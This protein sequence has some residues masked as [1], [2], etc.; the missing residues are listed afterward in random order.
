MQDYLTPTTENAEKEEHGTSTE[1]SRYVHVRRQV[2]RT[3]TDA[4]GKDRNERSRTCRKKRG[5]ENDY[6]ELGIGY[7]Q[8]SCQRYLLATCRRSRCKTTHTL[9]GKIAE[10]G[11]LSENSEKF[12]NF[13][14]LVFPESNGFSERFLRKIPHLGYL[15]ID[16]IPQVGYNTRITLGSG[17]IS[18][19]S[20]VVVTQSN[21][22]QQA[23][24]R[25]PT[26]RERYLGQWES[27]FLYEPDN[28]LGD[29][30][31]RCCPVL[32]FRQHRYLMAV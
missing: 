21:Q 2:C 12:S 4:P 11:Q 18:P 10:N 27:A 25:L 23:Y 5:I 32:A 13:S 31:D 20:R 15:P 3:A 28:P 1:G 16:T 7:P 9:A 24:C 30:G 6:P 22:N 29:I 19:R 17:S 26:V 14:T 8:A